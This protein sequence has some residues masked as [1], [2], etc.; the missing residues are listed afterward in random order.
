MGVKFNVTLDDEQINEIASI[1]ADKVLSTVKY[2]K[3]TED[4]YERKIQDLEY[5]LQQ[6]DG[7]LVQKDLYSERL[8]LH[9]DK[10]KNKV[11]ELKTQLDEKTE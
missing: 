8:K 5:S 1:T 9:I 3:N 4:Y 7:I 11:K 2:C 10:L 6:R